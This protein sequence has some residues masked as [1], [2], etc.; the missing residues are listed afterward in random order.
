[1][2]KTI[3][4]VQG[5]EKVYQQKGTWFDRL[6][7]RDPVKLYAVNQVDF[8]LKEGEILGLV[9]ESGCGKSTL[10]RT[11][12]RLSEPTGG[13]IRF[14]GEEITS[15]S[16]K[17]M[18]S[19]RKNMQMVFQDPYSSLNPK[20]TIR[21]MLSEAIRFHNIYKQ[22][23]EIR[24]YID[25]LMIKVGLNPE[26]ADKFPKAFSG[27]QRQRVA[28][29]RALAVQPKLIIADEPV[30]ALDVSVQAH[31]LQLL[32]NLQKELNLT[33]IF[34]SHDLS[35]VKYISDR[36]AVMYLGRIVEIGKTSE[37]FENTNHPYTKALLSAVPRLSRGGRNRMELEGDPPSPFEQSLGCSFYSRCAQRAEKCKS[38]IPELTRRSE[39][40]LSACFISKEM[41]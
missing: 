8:D 30:S 7:H 36:V 4:Q 24:Q 16:Q 12:M 10:S 28:I 37:V 34:I 35:V 2:T 26:D 39:T 14:L 22:E 17:H 6:F 5:L 40:H 11:I 1:M 41:S 27:G 32:K 18:Q 21:E 15:I 38:T 20:M 3:L 29:A 19:V 13:I 9:G 23:K 33:M 31:I 25:Q